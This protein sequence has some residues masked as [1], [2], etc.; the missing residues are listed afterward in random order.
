MRSSWHDATDQT[1]TIE[2][3]ESVAKAQVAAAKAQ[4]VAAML[5]EVQRAAEAAKAEL[6]A[7]D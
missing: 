4:E 5:A 2:R 1:A 6:S 7:V 3:E